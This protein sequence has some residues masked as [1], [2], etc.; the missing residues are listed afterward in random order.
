MVDQ[1]VTDL[2]ATRAMGAIHGPGW[3]RPSSSSRPSSASPA[4]RGA[5]GALGGVPEP[6][7]DAVH[8]DHASGAKAST[9]TR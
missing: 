2:I 5:A 4:G 8:V 7:D 1:A 9:I 6:P 3:A